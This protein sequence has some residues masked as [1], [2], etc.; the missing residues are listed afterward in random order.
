[1]QRS[2]L[3]VLL[4]IVA[5]PCVAHPDDVSRA[6]DDNR[7]AFP[8]HDTHILVTSVASESATAVLELA[9]PAKSVGAPPHR[10][11]K[12]DEFFYVL[13]GEVAFFTADTTHTLN[14]GEMIT[15]PRGNLHG[16]YNNT[17][18]PAR[19]LL[20]VSPGQ[21]A[22]FFDAVVMTLREEG[23]TADVGAVIAEQAAKFDVTIEMQALP[24]EAK[25][26]LKT[27]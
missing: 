18:A 9:V 1:M 27:P 8:G 12:E 13:E 10:H 17:D 24:E 5:A 26:L 6:N 22:S 7:L 19:L 2:T 11:A 4:F 20:V 21:F 14:A 15:L 16:F 25:K 3:A 23:K